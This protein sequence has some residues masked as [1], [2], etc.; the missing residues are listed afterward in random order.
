MERGA[1]VTSPDPQR[2][3]SLYSIP[4]VLGPKFKGKL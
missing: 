2:E 1:E 4:L 3:E